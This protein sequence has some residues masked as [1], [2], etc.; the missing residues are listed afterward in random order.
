MSD[1]TRRPAAAPAPL[2]DAANLEWLRKRARRRLREL[3]RTRP[4][5]RLADAQLDVAR[6]HGFP[7]WRALKAHVDALTLHGQLFDAARAGDVARLTALLDAHPDALHARAKPYEWTLLHAAAHAGQLAAVELLLQRGLDPNARER[8]DDT[9]AMHWAAAAGHLDVVRRLADAGGDVV[10]RGDDHELEVIGWATCWDGCDDA[11]HR[12]VADFLVSRGARHHIF[13]AIALDLADEVRR[14]VAA[15]PAALHR[16]MSRNE[17][18]Q[19]PLHFAV[20][21]G[22]PAM[23]ALL[24]A[25]GADPLGVDGSGMSAAVDAT[26]PHADRPLMEAIRT[27]TSAELRSAERGRRPAR[28]SALD[29]LAAL[30]LGEHDTAARLVRENPALLEPDAGV[31]HLMA[32]RG[33]AP[34]VRWLLQ[35]GADPSG[36]WSHWDAEVTPL[37]LAA[38]GGH[39]DVARLL[40]DAGADPRIRDSKHDGDARDWAEFF[41]RQEIVDLLA[42][43]EARS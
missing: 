13:S 11:A 2:P 43:H 38:L 39:A 23:V 32:K 36:R 14:I 26:A 6:H 40:L 19:L 29:L 9:Y 18:H 12:A 42:T 30:A 10:G 4:D 7:S 3:K 25:L 33:D 21:K 31:L 24:L 34:A 17:N 41:R 28:G 35:R 27:L 37:H 1:E 5:A 22:R 8:G 20:Q 16:R 15:D